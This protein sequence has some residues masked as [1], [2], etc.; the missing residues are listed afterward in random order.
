MT[1]RQNSTKEKPLIIRI[2]PYIQGSDGIG[3]V[4]GITKV[5]I[6]DGELTYIAD[7]GDGRELY[8]PQR[9]V[10]NDPQLSD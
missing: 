8:I 3:P 1:D 5:A 7:R 2:K 9:W 10:E 6:I 4:Y